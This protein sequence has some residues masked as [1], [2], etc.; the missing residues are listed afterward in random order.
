MKIILLRLLKP[1]AN[2]L[3]ISCDVAFCPCQLKP[4]N[5]V[6]M[7]MYEYDSETI[8]LP[9]ELA[10]SVDVLLKV[11]STIWMPKIV[12]KSSKQNRD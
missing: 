9:V 2:T 10:N 1:D 3:N 11:S 8:L 6:V 4:Y 5:T 12:N 7:N